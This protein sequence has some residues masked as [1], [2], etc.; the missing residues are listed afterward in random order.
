MT[1]KKS[2]RQRHDKKIYAK[3]KDKETKK[4]KKKT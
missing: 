1:L 3:Q 2:A 4:K